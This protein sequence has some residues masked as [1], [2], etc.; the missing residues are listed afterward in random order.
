M[1]YLQLLLAA[2]GTARAALDWQ[3]VRIG[4][5]GGFVPSIVFHPNAKGVAYARTDI[6]GIYR[7][8]SD[9]SWTPITDYIAQNDT[10]N[11][12]GIDAL[13]VDPSDPDVVLAAFGMYTNDWDPNAGSI[14]RSTD[15][16]KTWTFTEL[17]FKVGGNMPGRGMGERLAVD[18]TNSD[19]IYFGAR[20]GKGLWKSTDA[21]KTFSEVTSFP[22]PGTFN[23]N[24]NEAGGYGND[25]QGLAF[26]TFDTSAATANGATSRI[27]V[28]TADKTAESVYVSEDA[29]AT[30]TAIAGQPTGFLPH[31]GRVEPKEGA[32]YLTYSDGSGPYDGAKGAVYRYDIAKATW[33]DITPVTGEDLTWGYGGLALD[34]QNPGTLVVASLN[35]WWPDAQLFRSTDSGATWSQ[36]W[37]WANYPEINAKYKI[38]TPKAPWINHDFIA[39][40]SKKLGW[41]IESLEINP[42]DSDHWLYG[43]GLTV[44]G[45]HDLT[46]WDSNAS[47]NIES[48][49]DGIEEFAVLDLASAP[50]G[51]EL[52]AG[53]HDDSG[54]TFKSKADLNTSP[55]TAWNTPM[56]VGSSG[57]DYAGNSVSEVV[58]VGN[59]EGSAQLATSSDGGVT[60][61]LHP[62]NGSTQAGGSVALSADGTSVLWSTSGV[63]V[64][65]ST[66]QGPLSRVSSL[67][68]GSVIASDKRNDEVFYAG[69]DAFYV[70]T[71]GGAAFAKGGALQ[72]ANSVRS[73][74][75]HPTKAGD[76]WASTNVGIFHSTDSGKTFTLISTEVTNT[77]QVSLGVGANGWNV[78]TF[79]DGADGPKLYGSGN[80]GASWTDLQG[81]I[82]FGAVDGARIAGSGNEAGLVY[83]GTNGRGVFY[84]QGNL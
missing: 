35:S 27:F 46:N 54:F 73:I 11:R 77:W 78:Y 12:W 75:A 8:N 15:Q 19:I 37:T 55:K 22:N 16:G 6:G 52:F 59:V 13:A 18:P 33:T 10:W 64:Q 2:A 29:G 71:D 42:F 65:R 5:G 45:G 25:L 56:F 60:W 51:S 4:G 31:K 62:A 23:P 49:A 47:I 38:D 69:S 80:G 30:W 40:D 48:L 53:V 39:V 3:N 58:R 61:G 14:G 34:S 32:L 1:K 68:A 43:T 84:G 63:G 41:M 57:V 83:V 81:E 28:G 7:W 74:A 24:P 70:S 72:G 20:S 21:G 17:P 66:N 82:G 9:D 67:A 76:V 50:G 36:I 26:V 44:F 79:G